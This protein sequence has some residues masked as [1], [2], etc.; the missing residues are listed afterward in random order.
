MTKE[1]LHQLGE[2]V[3][4][5]KQQIAKHLVQWQAEPG[6]GPEKAG[7]WLEAV[8]IPACGGID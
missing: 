1:L 5:F 2:T 7:S 4:A 6:L 3:V 8:L